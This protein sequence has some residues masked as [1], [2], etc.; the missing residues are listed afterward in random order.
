MNKATGIHTR[1]M[2]GILVLATLVNILGALAYYYSNLNLQIGLLD[3]I[4]KHE[5]AVFAAAYERDPNVPL[6]DAALISVWFPARPG[7][8]PVPP[9]RLPRC[10]WDCITMSFTMVVRTTST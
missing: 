6:P 8:D 2:M 3:I 10:R 1:V 9:P 7:G 5:A 4:V